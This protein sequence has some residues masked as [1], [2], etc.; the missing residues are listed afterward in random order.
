MGPAIMPRATKVDSRPMA[1]PRSRAGNASVMMP[2]LLAMAIAAPTPCSTRAATSQL[3]VGDMPHASE[4]AVKVATPA[5]NTRTLPWESPSPP[6]HS[7][8]RHTT[9]R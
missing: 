5:W 2:M 8:K 9:M 3:S 7:T 6:N 4:P 1:R